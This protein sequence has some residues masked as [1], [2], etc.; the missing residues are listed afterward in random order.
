MIAGQGF[1]RHL[2]G[3]RVTAERLGRKPPALFSH[4]DFKYLSEF[5][6]ST[7]TLT[8]DTI[9]FGGFGPVVRDGFGIGYVVS[10]S[11]LGAVISSYRV[12]AFVLIFSKLCNGR[13]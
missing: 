2:M 5:V 8:T 10:S 9:C 6:I 3:L 12:C 13:V 7:S 4:P 1:D 11:K